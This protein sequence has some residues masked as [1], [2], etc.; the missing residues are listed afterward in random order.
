MNIPHT[1]MAIAITA[2]SIGLAVACSG[3]KEQNSE[4]SEART[5]MEAN[6][7]QSLSAARAEYAKGNYDSAQSIIEDMS[8]N[9]KLA[10]NAREEGILLTDSIYIAKSAARMDEIEKIVSESPDSLQRLQPEMEDL[11]RE[12]KFYHRKLEFDK[13]NKKQH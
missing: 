7:Q 3:K 1:L 12:I 5:E 13:K 8:K 9:Y 2:V 4:W 11:S 6:G 10:F